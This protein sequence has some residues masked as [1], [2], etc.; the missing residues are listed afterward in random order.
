MKL[1]STEQA[2]EMLGAKPSTLRNWR[3]AKTG[4]PFIQI[5]KRSVKY[6]QEDIEKY[7]AERRFTPSVRVSEVNH[8][9][10]LLANARLRYPVVLTPAEEGGFVVT[11]PDIPEAITQ[12][13]D[14]ESALE[15]GLDALI[16]S[17]D[18]Y[19]D[20]KRT[21]PLPSAIK[22]GQTYI[23]I[24]ARLSSKILSSVNR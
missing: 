21:V 4:P 23:D 7:V 11:F 19:F 18:F 6:S 15:M 20:D 1:I 14:R 3:C 16:T 9:A 24:P 10:A 17:L 8:H 13:D 5:T 22:R 2:A 12:G